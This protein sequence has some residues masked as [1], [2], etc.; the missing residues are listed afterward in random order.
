M[1]DEIIVEMALEDAVMLAMQVRCRVNGRI[2][3][4]AG[5]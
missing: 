1:G 5:T 4:N 3:S 2:E